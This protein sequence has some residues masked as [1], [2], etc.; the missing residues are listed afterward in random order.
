MNKN[1]KTLKHILNRV[2]KKYMIFF[3]NF[4][5][6]HVL[7]IFK[8]SLKKAFLFLNLLKFFFYIKA[9]SFKNT[10]LVS[11]NWK[12]GNFS[13]LCLLSEINFS[14]TTADL[15]RISMQFFE[16]LY[17]NRGQWKSCLFYLYCIC[18]L[19]LF[20]CLLYERRGEALPCTYLTRQIDIMHFNFHSSLYY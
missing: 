16:L 5:N 8:T 7:S 9:F 1:K 6:W 4:L 13:L 19:L 3:L 14:K 2:I 20:N 15:W 18:F 11:S 10:Q 12:Q 17:G